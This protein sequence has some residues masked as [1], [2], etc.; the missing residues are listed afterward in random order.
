MQMNA[1]LLAGGQVSSTDPLYDES[2]DGRRCLI[3]VLGKPMIQWVIDALANSDSVDEL[4]VVGLP[5]EYDLSAEKPLTYLPD[6]GDM[7]DNI[8][9]G[10]RYSAEKHPGHSK[11]FIVSADI[12]ALRPEMVDWTAGIVEKNPDS[13]LYYNV[14]SRSVM[15]TRFPDA[16]RSY[17]RFKDITVCG[18]DLNVVDIKFFQKESPVWKKLTQARKHPLKQASL[19]GFDTLLL[20]ALHMIT[21]EKAVHMV[22]KRLML[23]GKV[24]VSPYA[25]IGMD[26]DKPHQLKILRQ[27]LE[28]CV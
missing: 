15:D 26:A 22:C 21:L 28:G 2:P 5:P 13:T 25:E 24:L 27:T 11:C 17:V 18:G 4:F 20:A 6:A 23:E 1:V 8:R 10:V 7:F 3:D 12:P 19:L 9:C 14:I 16:N